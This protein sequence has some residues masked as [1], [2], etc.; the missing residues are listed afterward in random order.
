MDFSSDILLL[1]DQFDSVFESDTFCNISENDWEVEN[2]MNNYVDSLIFDETDEETKTY[3]ILN[4]D[5]SRKILE[6]L[7]E[8]EK[9]GK[10]FFKKSLRL[11]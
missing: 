6:Q 11:L 1:P 7:E 5:V 10:F 8:K 2:E 3:S 4:N 9:T